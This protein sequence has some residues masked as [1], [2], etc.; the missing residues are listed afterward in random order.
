MKLYINP[1][2]FI[3]KKCV[4]LSNSGTL[5]DTNEQNQYILEP[6]YIP[7]AGTGDESQYVNYI[8]YNLRSR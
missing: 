2:V 4:A 5:K 7:T 8:L 1:L 6:I 3:Q